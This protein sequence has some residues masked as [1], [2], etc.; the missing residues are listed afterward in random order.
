MRKLY[1]YATLVVLAHAVVVLWHLELLA[2][3]GSALKPEQVPLFA[4][5]ANLI[6]VVAVILLWADFPKV[7]A[8]LLLFLAVP[9]AIGGYSHFLSP[10]FDNVFRMAPGELTLAFRVSAVLLLVLELLSCW[11]AVQIL[12]D[13][14][15]SVAGA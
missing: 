3:L 8:W 2:R 10:G 13:S 12:R 15:L 7:G 6:P 14:S 1:W 5:L 11:V 9:L 4:I